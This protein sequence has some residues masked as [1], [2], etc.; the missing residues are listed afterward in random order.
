VAPAGVAARVVALRR[1]EI[2]EYLKARRI[3]F[4]ADDATL[5][6]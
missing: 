1:L 4:R 3:R 6:E 2:P 5:A